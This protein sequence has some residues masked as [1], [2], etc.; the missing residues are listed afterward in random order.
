MQGSA[1]QRGGGPLVLV[2]HEAGKTA[3]KNA[4][5]EESQLPRFCKTNGQKWGTMQAEK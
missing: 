1:P 3:Q 5:K 2:D 4:E